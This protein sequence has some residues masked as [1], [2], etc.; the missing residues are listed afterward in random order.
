MQD[1]GQ[2]YAET[3]KALEGRRSAPRSALRLA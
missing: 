1:C 2:H 3:Y